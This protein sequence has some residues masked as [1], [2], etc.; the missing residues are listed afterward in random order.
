MRLGGKV[1]RYA[2]GSKWDD[3]GQ[4]PD[5]EAIGGLVEFRGR[6]YATSLYKP[7]GFF[8]YDGERTWKSLPT[9]GGKRTESLAVFNGNIFA[10]SYD[11]GHVYRFDGETWTDCGQLGENTQ[12]YSFAIHEGRLF[13]G[14]WPSGRVY[15]FVK[16]NEWEDVGRLG[17]ELEVMGMMVHNGKLFAGTLP[18]ASVYRFDGLGR[19]TH[20]GRLDQT[21][22]VKYRR[23]WTMAEFQGRLFCGTLPTGHVLSIEA[24]KN[25]TW[26]EELPPGWRHVAAVRSP[27]KLELFVDG[28]TVGSSSA[29]DPADYDLT[30]DQP[31][32]I[33]FGPGDYF[34]GHLRDVRL[35]RRALI[36]DEI[37]RLARPIA[38]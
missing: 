13:V 24:G 35:Y 3:C 28:R 34:N 18:L 33:G 21:P 30:N 22:D 12:T 19:W 16:D 1:F 32:R 8:V 2:G 5:T 4:L 27:G 6:L 11:G 7:A 36:R 23:A 26:D 15:R 38:P 20:I 25:V 14:T 10:G 17:E 9:P 37:A 29:F 31:L